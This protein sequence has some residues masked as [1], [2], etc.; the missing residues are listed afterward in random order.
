MHIYP[1]N[2]PTPIQAPKPKLS[3]RNDHITFQQTRQMIAQTTTDFSLF[4]HLRNQ[5][6]TFPYPTCIQRLSPGTTSDNQ[7]S[8]PFLEV[9][10]P[11]LCL[12]PGYLRLL[13]F[14]VL[15]FSRTSTYK[16]YLNLVSSNEFLNKLLET[17]PNHNINLNYKFEV[18]I[19]LPL[20][21]FTFCFLV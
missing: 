15:I 10:S 20:P 19:I 16:K 6:S 8:L 12:Y 5:C 21:F 17:P 18:S 1:T 9:I 14:E 2:T 3:N 4:S 7:T 11:D 13:P